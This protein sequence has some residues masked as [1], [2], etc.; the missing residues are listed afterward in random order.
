MPLR[1]SF[2][3]DLV[4]R[5]MLS[6]NFVAA[7]DVDSFGAITLRP[8]A[9][10]KVGGSSRRPIYELELA[11]PGGE[12]TLRRASSD[13]VIHIMV[14]ETPGTPWLGRPPWVLAKL[15]AE[16]LAAIENSLKMDSSVPSGVLLPIPDGASQLAK[17][18]IAN[19]LTRG[20][21]AIS[22]VETTS[23]GYGGGR[24]AAPR[25]DYDQK[26]FGAAV[27]E[28]NLK[29]RDQ[30][31]LAIL[32]SYG[33]SP[34]VLDGDGNA[35]REARRA[36]YLDTIL[37][38]AAVVSQ[39]LSLKLDATVSLDFNPSQYRDFQRLSRSLKTFIDAGL[40]LGQASSI[41]GISLNQASPPLGAGRQAATLIGVINHESV[42]GEVNQEGTPIDLPLDT[43]PGTPQGLRVA[44]KVSGMVVGEHGSADV[45]ALCRTHGIGKGTSPN[46]HI[47]HAALSW[48]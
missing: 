8:A 5:L 26:R 1:A 28:A 12:P 31:S 21:G 25:D 37:P 6:G 20:K 11:N 13:G 3:V 45:C 7:I 43:P 29:M 32:R 2:L 14:N 27:P 19:A 41:L 46:G 44:H 36:L 15:T 33:V 39:E 17:N 42:N 22:P 18:A 16:G 23:G 24:L 40:S 47:E 48:D 30:T 9:S 10:F 4:R 38:L 35:M 34:K